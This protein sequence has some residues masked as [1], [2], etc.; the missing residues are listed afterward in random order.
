[1]K[2]LRS[3]V[4]TPSYSIAFG[5]G[6]P[7]SQ[8]LA[9]RRPEGGQKLMRQ[10]KMSRFAIAVLRTPQRGIVVHNFTRGHSYDSHT[11]AGRGFFSISSISCRF[12]VNVMVLL[13]PF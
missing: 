5:K 6:V 8:A 10:L 1:M 12:R 9:I 11:L 7:E 4:D 2:S 13:M 3:K